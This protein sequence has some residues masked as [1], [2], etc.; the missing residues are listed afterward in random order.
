MLLLTYLKA[1]RD[2]KYL[3]IILL[4]IMS[5]C[6]FYEADDYPTPHDGLIVES[7]TKSPDGKCSIKVV[8]NSVIPGKNYQLYRYFRD[9][10]CDK[11]EIGDTITLN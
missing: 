4:G 11:W 8:Y 3:L 9:C 5:S 1:Y 7:I 10:P 6:E 2:M